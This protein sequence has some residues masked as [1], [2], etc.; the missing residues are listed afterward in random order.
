MRS[1][2]IVPQ[3]PLHELPIE[4]S[5][6]VGKRFLVIIGTFFLNGAVKPLNVG[7]HLRMFGV[8]MKVNQL[9]AFDILS[10]MLLKL[11]AVVRLET[12]EREWRNVLELLQKVVA[13]EEEGFL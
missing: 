4:D 5:E 11:T 2:G 10:E 8:G 7:V 9:D 12:H 1:F 3:E 13:L 6:V